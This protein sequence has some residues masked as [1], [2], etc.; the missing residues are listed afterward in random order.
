MTMP[1]LKGLYAFEAIVRKGSFKAAAEE[2]CLSRSAVSHQIKALEDLLKVPLFD[3]QQTGISMTEAGQMLFENLSDAFA[4]VRHAMTRM[5][6]TTND[7]IVNIALPP[8]FALKWL[9][10]RLPSLRMRHPN[11]QLHMSYPVDGKPNFDPNVQISIN[12]LANHKADLASL[13]LVDGT[14]YPVCSPTLL[15]TM[16][17]GLEPSD[18]MQFTL[19]HEK[20]DLYWRD[21]FSKAGVNTFTPVRNEIF[22]DSNVVYQAVMEGQGIALICPSLVQQEL[23]SQ[24]LIRPFDFGLESYAY[25][26]TVAPVYKDHTKIIRVLDWLRDQK[27]A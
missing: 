7:T 23:D 15:E 22:D 12:W 19:L 4:L 24:Q 8:H 5:A 26:A 10:P 9:L 16:R 11:I 21:W 20:N 2:L 1:P 25:Y 17:K 6:A 3:R 27:E 13:R 14:L 18:L